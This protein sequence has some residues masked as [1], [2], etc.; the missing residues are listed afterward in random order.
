MNETTIPLL[1]EFVAGPVENIRQ[2]APET[3]VYAPGGTRRSA[4][5]S[6]IEPWSEKHMVWART[7]LIHNI[8]LIFQ[9]GVRHILA[10]AVTPTNVQEAHQHRHKLY[11]MADWVLAGEESLQYYARNGWRVRMVGGE[12]IAE[13]QAAARRLVDNTAQRAE[14]TLWWLIMPEHNTFWNML[15]S[16]AHRTPFNIREEI[17]QAIFGEIVPPATLLLAFGKP[18]FSLGLLPPFLFDEVECYWTQRVGY[19]LD[20]E[21]LRT[22]FYDYAYLRKT[23]QPDKLT[24]AYKATAHQAAWEEGPILGL[25]MRLGPFWYPAPMSSPAWFT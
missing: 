18:T 24:R 12:N 3:M 1:D 2:V 5:F 25:G 23:W 19:S 4:V 15:L 11:A 10:P 21:Q 22:V 8:D 7:S 6:K 16:S 9:H 14:H 13:L 17:V 20:Q